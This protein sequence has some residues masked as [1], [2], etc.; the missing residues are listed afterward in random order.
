MPPCIYDDNVSVVSSHVYFTNPVE[1]CCTKV[2]KN[3]TITVGAQR[4]I[5]IFWKGAGDNALTPPPPPPPCRHLSQIHKTKYM[6]LYGKKKL[7]EKSEPIGGGEAPTPFWIRHCKCTLS[8]AVNNGSV[9]I[10]TESSTDGATAT[11]PSRMN[12]AGDIGNSGWMFTIACCLAV[13]LGLD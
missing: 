2:L 12:F 8:R 5:Q 10:T 9:I 4:Q 1:R 6:L 11:T 7:L 13:G 3:T